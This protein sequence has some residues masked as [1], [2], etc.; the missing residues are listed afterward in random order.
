MKVLHPAAD[1][2][3]GMLQNV[4]DLDLDRPARPEA[5]ARRLRGDRRL[6][7]RRHRAR[8]PGPAGRSAARSPTRWPA[9]SPV[10]SCSSTATRRSS[11]T[12]RSARSEAPRPILLD[13]CDRDR[14]VALLERD[15]AR[16]GLPRGRQQ[17]RADPRAP[18]RRG[19]PHQRAQHVVAGQRRRRARL[20]ALRPPLHRQGRPPLLGDGRHQAGGRAHRGRRRPAPRPAVR[21]GAV[22]QRAG[23]PRQ[24]GADV[25]APDPRRGAGDGH[26]ART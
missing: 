18:R 16:G 24:R 11:T 26:R 19:G 14:V 2:G 7:P 5:G 15:P 6:P 22:R 13:I 8:R 1:T 4:R 10:A 25:P 9:T 23:E 17:A 12:S 21:R 3:S 20:P